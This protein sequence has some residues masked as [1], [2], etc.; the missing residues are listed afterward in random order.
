MTFFAETAEQA[1]QAAVLLKLEQTLRETAVA[2]GGS[3]DAAALAEMV[4]AEEVKETG[5][6]RVTV[7]SADSGEGK[8]IADAVAE[9]LPK[10]AEAV[11]GGGVALADPAVLARDAAVPDRPMAG[12]VGGIMG[13][14]LAAGA[15][16]FGVVF[17]VGGNGERKM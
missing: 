1:R 8:A 7:R 10:R 6:L 12:L 15:V 14:F 3:Y 9:V 13:V 4:T 5:F 2:A 17:T 16:G 11:L